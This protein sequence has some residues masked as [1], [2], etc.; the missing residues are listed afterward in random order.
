VDSAGEHDG[1]AERFFRW[2][3]I[4][5]FLAMLVLPTVQHY[6]PFVDCL[7]VDENRNKYARPNASLVD[8][9]LNRDG[10]A[11][12]YEKYYND[13]YGF[14]DLF[15][16]C[17]N[18]IDYSVFSKSDKV[19]I[20]RDGWL[21]YRS[22]LDV[23]EVNMERLG[24]D[25]EH[26]FIRNVDRL[27]EFL[28]KRGATLIVMPFPQKNSLLPEHVP[29]TAPRR[30][31]ETCFQRYCAALKR[32]PNI[33]YFDAPQLLSDLKATQQIYYRTDFH[34]TDVAAYF[35]SREFVAQVSRL[36]GKTPVYH[37][38]KINL[39]SLSGGQAT[40]IPMLWTPTEIAPFP[41]KNW[42]DDG[43]FELKPGDDYACTFRSK[44]A[45]GLPPLLVIGDSFNEGMRR[46]GFHSYFREVHR[47]HN[48]TSWAE[49]LAA[50]PQVKYVLLEHI[51]VGT[52]I[53]LQMPEKL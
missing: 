11:V 26:A 10:A 3:T 36:E 19:H 31:A 17:K 9:F 24:A 28:R 13:H 18:Q 37:E 41:E 38:L 40:F 45:D 20:G 16:R 47:I 51:E 27:A 44:K 33:I 25:N 49:I 52:E 53:L 46:T 48:R 22:V 21:F 15:I 39:Q 8:L 12:A 1:V 43:T 6:Y 32:D 5:A 14:R 35:V 29:S 42:Q 7:K 23:Q 50:L 34:Y 30:P 4:V 2:A